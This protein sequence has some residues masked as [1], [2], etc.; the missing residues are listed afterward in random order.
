MRRPERIVDKYVCQGSEPIREAGVV[1]CFAS[2]E[3]RVL[4]HDDCTLR[5]RLDELF[6]ISS[7]NSRGKNRVETAKARELLGDRPH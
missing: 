4:E 5:S 3:S 7:D 2:L 1:G 6:N